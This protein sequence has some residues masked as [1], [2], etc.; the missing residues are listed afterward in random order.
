VPARDLPAF[1]PG[2]EFREQVV[3]TSS[4]GRPE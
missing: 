1:T 2:K 4:N 3:T